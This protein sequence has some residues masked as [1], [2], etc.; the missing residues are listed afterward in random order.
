[1]K[2]TPSICVPASPAAAGDLNREVALLRTIVRDQRLDLLDE[3]SEDM[4]LSVVKIVYRRIRALVNG[5]GIMPTFPIIFG[6]G[7]ELDGCDVFFTEQ[8]DP[9]WRA[10]DKPEEVEDAL[11]HM[12]LGRDM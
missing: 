11:K 5:R 9:L 8:C 12:R 6:G 10:F 7:F 3:L 2:V 4:F 1:M